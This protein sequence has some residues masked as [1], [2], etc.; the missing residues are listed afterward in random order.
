M[1]CLLFCEHLGTLLAEKILCLDLCAFVI[2]KNITFS[3]FLIKVVC[4]SLFFHDL[5]SSIFK[6]SHVVLVV[7][8]CIDEVIV[9]EI[10]FWVSIDDRI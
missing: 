2:L 7:A 1:T 10:V 6:R 8:S 5:A 3:S 9:A 4:K